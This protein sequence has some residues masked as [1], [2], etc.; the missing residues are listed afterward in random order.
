MTARDDVRLPAE[1]Y[2]SQITPA[3]LEALRG[4][5]SG[6]LAPETFLLD[7]EINIAAL[8]E[9]FAI[10]Y[11]PMDAHQTQLDGGGTLLPSLPRTFTDEILT[12][13][14]GG[15]GMDPER[16]DV[17]VEQL[18]AWF[19]DCWSQVSV[20][21]AVPAFIGLHDSVHSFDLQGNAWVTLDEKWP[22]S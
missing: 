4:V 21:A 18:I 22:E 20:N 15:G 13:S 8:R 3:L 14:P 5:I 11:D 7:F 12:G 2:L 6:P 10:R 16:V 1:Q 9:C 17:A 19:S